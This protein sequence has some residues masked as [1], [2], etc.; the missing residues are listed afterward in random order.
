M[1]VDQ[2]ASVY[3]FQMLGPLQ[4]CRD[5]VAV[6]LPARHP[7]MLLA[8]LL[9]HNGEIVA[10]GQLLEQVWDHGVGSVIALRTAV[11]RL[12]SW[13]RDTVGAVA[14]IEHVDGG[15]RLRLPDGSVDATRFRVALAADSDISGLDPHQRLANLMNALEQW[16]GPVLEGAPDGVR[17]DPV[18][19]ALDDDHATCLQRLAAL[20]I[21]VQAPELLLPRTRALAQAR[22]FD[23]P[24]HTRLIELYAACGRPAEALMEYERLRS[25]LADELGVAPSADAQR[26][27]L[28]VLDQDP[29]V[30]GGFERTYGMGWGRPVV[31]HQIPADIADFT[32]RDKA[33]AFL[34]DHLSGVLDD[35]MRP[36]AP[37]AGVTGPAGAGKS[38]LAVHLAHRLV[39]TYTDG[40]LYADLGGAGA[41]PEAPARVLGRFL[42]ALGVGHAAVPEDLAERTALYRSLMDN[43][44]ILVVLDNAVGEAQV[45]PLLP[46][47]ATCSV[48]ITSRSRLV[49]IGGARIVDLDRFEVDH[50][51]HLLASIV[52]HERLAAE[53]EAAAELVQLCD[54]LPLAV[55]I[56]GARLAARPHWPISGLVVMLRDEHRRLDEL[57]V[58]DLAIRDGLRQSHSRLRE[59]ARKALAQLARLGSVEFAVGTAAAVCGLNHADA[60]ACLDALV[61]ARFVSVVASGQAGRFHYRLDD[62]V[63]L[64]VLDL[65]PAR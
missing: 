49:G 62:L 22:P 29:P 28:A 21:S 34:L 10:E 5:G 41:V 64:F 45:R 2:I 31:P 23:E 8:A 20:A 39:P 33:T 30:L 60:E 47:S 27:H 3:D 50:A 44:R 6:A 37:V 19:R 54:R 18:V 7:R 17:E 24:L 26:A 52:G 11:S 59:D 9:L 38:A 57:S 46:G 32:G 61:E 51:V 36:A 53:P 65:V 25:R 42:R 56:C 13:L 16:R 48:L 43:R 14:S 58:A 1:T 63:R 35:P 55:R 12:R 40:Q 4:V 15:Y